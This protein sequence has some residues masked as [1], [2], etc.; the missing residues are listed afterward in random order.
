MAR[1]TEVRRRILQNIADRKD[2]YEG[3]SGSSLGGAIRSLQTMLG[4]YPLI[5][6]D[7]GEAPDDNSTRYVLTSKGKRALKTG[8]Y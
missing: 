8:R 6:L 7:D 5:D 2:P 4:L 1:L 3:F